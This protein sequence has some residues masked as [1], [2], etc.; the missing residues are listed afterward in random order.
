MVAWAA[1]SLGCD[2]SLGIQDLTLL[3]ASPDGEAGPK[4]IVRW[5][6]KSAQAIGTCPSGTVVL[7][8][9]VSER[10]PVRRGASHGDKSVCN[11]GRSVFRGVGLHGGRLL[12]LATRDGWGGNDLLR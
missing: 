4:L 7:R 5:N 8:I 3:D 11:L 10:L 9:C 6:L 12:G 2:Q 1:V